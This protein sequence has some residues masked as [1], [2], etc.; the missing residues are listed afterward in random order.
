M[1]TN[2]LNELC[3]NIIEKISSENGKCNHLVDVNLCLA[4]KLCEKAMENAKKY[5]IEITVAVVNKG[6]NL[7]ILKKMD[8]AIVASIDVSYKK[9]YTALSL[10]CPSSKV[11]LVQFPGLEELMKD[12]I[13]LFGGGYPINYNGKLIGGLG[14][15]GGSSVQDEEI[16]KNTIEDVLK[17]L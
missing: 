17:N 2:E 14:I 9:A 12:K 3:K 5:G 6:G 7:V 11:D 13:V 4:E 16:A 1:N 8:E 10:N 15:S